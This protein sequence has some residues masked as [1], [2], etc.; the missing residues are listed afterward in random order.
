[1]QVSSTQEYFRL[2]HRCMRATV[3]SNKRPIMPIDL[4]NPCRAL[5]VG[6]ILVNS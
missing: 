3:Y 5:C 2:Y 4:K 6:V 1:M